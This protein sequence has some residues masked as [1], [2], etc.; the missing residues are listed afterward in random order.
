MTEAISASLVSVVLPTLNGSRYIASSLESILAQTHRN[1]EVIVVDGG[2]HD[3]TLEIVAG[4]HDTRVRILS[5]PGNVGRLPGALNAGFA[6]ASGDFLTWAQDDDFFQPQAIQTMLTHLLEHPEVGLVY[7]GFW[8]MNEEGQ[9]IRESQL[10]PPE[11]MRWTNPIGHCFLYRRSAAEL[12]GRYDPA[13]FMAEDFHYWVRLSRVAEIAGLAERLYFHR[14]H[15]AS[16]T[17][18]DYGSYYALR[19]AA[20]IRRKLLGLGWFEYQRQQAAAYIE[21]AFAAHQLQDR[22]RVRR[23]LMRGL[24]RNPGWL[25]NR[26]VVSIG[27]QSLF[28]PGARRAQSHRLLGPEEQ[29]RNLPDRHER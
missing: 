20:R 29:G 2:S 24:T 10:H 18:R 23:C 21:E 1:L 12:V 26:G 17:V 13:F 5:Q 9:V 11:A 19:L 16:L 25:R 15:P 22:P 7:T 14:L 6:G 3:M 4:F 27:V 8:F 28:G